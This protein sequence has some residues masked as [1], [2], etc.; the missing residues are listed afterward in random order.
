M[1]YNLYELI[2]TFIA[3]LV[4]CFEFTFFSKHRWCSTHLDFCS[5]NHHFIAFPF[6]SIMFE[7]NIQILSFSHWIKNI[8]VWLRKKSKLWLKFL[9]KNNHTATLHLWWASLA[10]WSRFSLIRAW[11][12]TCPNP[13]AIYIPYLEISSSRAAAVKH[14]YFHLRHSIVK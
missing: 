13:Y 5:N 4:T 7:L 9:S 11:D 10:T 14:N 1:N 6:L 2:H 12:E 3:K 8:F